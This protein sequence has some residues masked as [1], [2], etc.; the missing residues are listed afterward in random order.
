MRGR[1]VRSQPFLDRGRAGGR[2]Q[3]IH[4]RFVGR[5]HPKNL[6]DTVDNRGRAVG[7]RR[8]LVATVLFFAKGHT[9]LGRPRQV[10]A[11]GA[12][13]K[14]LAA[15]RIGAGAVQ[16]LGRNRYDLPPLHADV[17]KTGTVANFY[18]RLAQHRVH[19]R[20]H[21]VRLE[22][23]AAHLRF[24]QPGAAQRAFIGAVRIEA[25][26][27]V[28]LLLARKVDRPA[29]ANRVRAQSRSQLIMHARPP[30]PRLP[31][32]DTPH[33]RGAAQLCHAVQQQNARTRLRTRGAYRRPKAARTTAYNQ[34]ISLDHISPQLPVPGSQ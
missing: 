26:E 18:T 34:N 30:D 16:R 3:L 31:V 7:G 33:R 17:G 22:V 15:N 9:A 1:P 8:L 19:R 32:V 11:A 6:R 12:V 13:D 4:P 5:R 10:T 29:H 20:G 14:E 28:W 2:R 25:R 23:D 24:G 27:A 21:H